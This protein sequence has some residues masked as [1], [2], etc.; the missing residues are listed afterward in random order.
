MAEPS[1]HWSCISFSV[2]HLSRTR[3]RFRE[4]AELPFPSVARIAAQFFQDLFA[5]A[6]CLSARSVG[7]GHAQ[8]LDLFRRQRMDGNPKLGWNWLIRVVLLVCIV[9]AAGKELY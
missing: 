4:F 8:A 7:A 2:L 9:R 3:S 6:R 1:A 5:Q